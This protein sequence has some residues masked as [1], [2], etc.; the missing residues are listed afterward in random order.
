M[1][2]SSSENSRRARVW[3]VLGNHDAS[4]DPADVIRALQATGIQALSNRRFQSKKDAGRF[5]LGGVEDVLGGT[6]DLRAALKNIPAG[7]ATVLLAHEPD[8]ADHVARYPVDLQLSGHSH[9][10]QVRLPFIPP[11]FLPDL[12]EEIIWGYTT[13]RP[14]YPV[15]HCGNRDGPCA[16]SVQLLTRDHT[17]QPQAS[18]T[19]QLSLKMHSRSFICAK[20]FTGLISFLTR[21]L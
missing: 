9:G 3:A 10:G 21:Y 15:H 12:G 20:D 7:E 14:A 11:L 13:C 16:R 18:L 8:F 5:W 6:P 4:S 2:R 19:T 17:D 1:C